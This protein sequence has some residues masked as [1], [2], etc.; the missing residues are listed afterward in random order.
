MS[1]EGRGSMSGTYWK[2]WGRDCDG[3]GFLEWTHFES[4]DKALSWLEESTDTEFF[5]RYLIKFVNGIET[6]THRTVKELYQK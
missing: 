5:P 1:T 4:P 3:E 6:S 2:W